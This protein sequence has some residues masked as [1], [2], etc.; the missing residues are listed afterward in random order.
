MT[1]YFEKELDSEDTYERVYVKVTIDDDTQMIKFDVDF[2]SIPGKKLDGFEV[3]TD[4]TV[5]NFDNN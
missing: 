5:D 4:F 1:F 3:I 2:D